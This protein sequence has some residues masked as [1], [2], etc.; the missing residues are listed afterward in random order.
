MDLLVNNNTITAII[1]GSI[2]TRT[3]SDVEI[4]EVKELILKYQLDQSD[5]NKTKIK[6]YLALD[7]NALAK[8]KEIDEKVE[9]IEKDIEIHDKEITKLTLEK[10]VF[11]EVNPYPDLI[12]SNENSFFLIG[13]ENVFMPDE[14]VKKFIK[15]KEN[16]EDPNSLINFWKLCLL[17][18]DPKARQGLFKFIQKQNLIVTPKGYVVCYRRL[19]K[20][21]EEDNQ[22]LITYVFSEAVRI[23]SQK[24]SLSKFSIGLEDGSPITLS[25]NTKKFENFKGEIVGT[26]AELSE[27][28]KTRS[29]HGTYTD[30]HT[31]TMSI[32]LGTAVKIPRSEC[33]PSPTNSCSRGLHVGTP[34]FLS[35]GGFGS[36]NVLVLVNPAHVV[37]VPYSDA[38]KMRVCEYFPCYEIENLDVIKSLNDS[39]ITTYEDDYCDYEI[40]QVEKIIG[41]KKFDIE[42][43]ECDDN[44]TKLKDRKE[45]ISKDKEDY[46][47][48]KNELLKY[49]SSKDETKENLTD[50]NKIKDLLKSR[51]K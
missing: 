12:G 41:T 2:Y 24:S 47:N 27:L 34:S 20:L 32:Q 43:F 22:T 26:V 23:K 7:R 4:K 3:F 25:H 44:I 39:S 17:N 21:K 46:L 8:A 30:A 49:F 15:C 40:D 13:F 14:L 28:Y 1:D 42:L 16:G 51:T 31:K 37:S 50:I 11:T 45:K 18:S 9:N 29:K 35:S 38:H 48:R 5:E 10:K 33:D 19:V 6:N 36:I